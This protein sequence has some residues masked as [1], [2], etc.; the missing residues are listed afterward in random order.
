MDPTNPFTNNS[1]FVDLL[2][3]QQGSVHD[4][5]SRY[6]CFSQGIDE[7]TPSERSTRKK[8]SITEDVV[9]ISA[10]LNTSKDPIVSN[11]QKAGA[12][13]KRIAAY[14]AAS[15][16]IQGGE[17]RESIQCKQRWQKINDFVSKFCG[18]YEVATRQKTSG[19][20]ENDVLQLA[21]QIFH[22]DHKIKFNFQHAWEELRYDQKWCAVA[23]S[24]MD[25]S[26]KKRKC[27]D[28]AQSSN[29]YATTNDVEERPPGVKAAKRNAKR[30]NEDLSQVQSLCEVKKQAA[31][32][33][34]L[35]TLIAKTEALSESEE[36]LKKNLIAE[37]LGKLITSYFDVFY[38]SVSMCVLIVVLIAIVALFQ[39][40]H[41]SSHCCWVSTSH[42]FM[43]LFL[44]VFLVVL[45]TFLMSCGHHRVEKQRLEV[46]RGHGRGKA[47]IV[48][49]LLFSFSVVYLLF[50]CVREVRLSLLFSSLTE[51]AFS[52]LFCCV[53]R[54]VLLCHKTV[55]VFVV[56]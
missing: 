18:S 47:E 3:R 51:V 48:V 13:W 35:Q 8:W 14:F 4:S 11:E 38:C 7:D 46:A 50:C 34:V 31:K 40:A 26:C 10:W 52:L 45:I 55:V 1:N 15:P 9:L 24:K 42:S 25:G 22:N 30:T 12:F 37:M 2:T 27:D 36:A 20:N 21:H 32:M 19:M 23:S 44:V 33:G 28:G 53:T 43:S 16:K 6:E 29:S 49:V 56:L 39:A 54:L 5:P 41:C 17:K